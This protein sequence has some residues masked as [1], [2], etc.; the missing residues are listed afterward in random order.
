MSIHG[1][2]D[3][4]A[5]HITQFTFKVKQEIIAKGIVENMSYINQ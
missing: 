2:L 4:Q 3:T 1:E 5:E